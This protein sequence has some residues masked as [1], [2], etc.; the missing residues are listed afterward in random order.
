MEEE[1]LFAMLHINVSVLAIVLAVLVNDLFKNQQERRSHKKRSVWIKHILR[2]RQEEGT[3][4]LLIPKLLDNNKQFQNFFRM[5]KSSFYFLLNL[6][7]S[8]L[9]RKDTRWRRSISAHE[10]LALTL[11]YLATGNTLSF[12]CIS[13]FTNTGTLRF[14]SF[15]SLLV[16]N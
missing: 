7:E 3:F 4:Q 14:K 2:K 6:V 16:S 13:R 15:L 9:T 8:T 11:C 1:L 5:S 12:I 10:R